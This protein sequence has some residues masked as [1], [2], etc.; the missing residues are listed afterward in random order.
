[1]D[2]KAIHG[3]DI[4]ECEHVEVEV[5]HRDA[6]RGWKVLYVHIDGITVLRVRIDENALINCRLLQGIPV[7]RTK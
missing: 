1:M 5:Q 2:I 6:G 7:R 4:V 3:L